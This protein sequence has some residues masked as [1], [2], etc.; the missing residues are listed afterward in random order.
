M[1]RNELIDLMLA[2][3][4]GNAGNAARRRERLDR[5]SDRRLIRVATFRGLIED[6]QDEADGFDDEALPVIERS[7]LDSFGLSIGMPR[8]E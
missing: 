1:N 8:F 4:L 5:M 3:E 7:T 6:D 2:D